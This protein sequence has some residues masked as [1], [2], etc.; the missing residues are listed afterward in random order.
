MAERPLIGLGKRVGGS[1]TKRPDRNLKS[2]SR[3]GQRHLA[4]GTKRH[5]AQHANGRHGPTG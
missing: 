2:L 5:F 4:G 3:L 1:I